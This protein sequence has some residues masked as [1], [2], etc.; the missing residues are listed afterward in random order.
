MIED[1]SS[2]VRVMSWMRKK[3]T[4][5]RADGKIFGPKFGGD[6]LTLLWGAPKLPLFANDTF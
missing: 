2:L 1:E 3:K 6:L 4:K 5:K